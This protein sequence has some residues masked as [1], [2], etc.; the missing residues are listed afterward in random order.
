MRIEVEIRT[1]NCDLVGCASMDVQYA[2][3]YSVSQTVPSRD[4]FFKS[5]VPA[6]QLAS[7]QT[8]FAVIFACQDVVVLLDNSLM[9]KN[10]NV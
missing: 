1:C 8:S 5:A 2:C 4:K 6:L 9:R 7:Y 10:R 3:C